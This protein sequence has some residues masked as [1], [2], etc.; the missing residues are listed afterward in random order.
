MVQKLG[1]W[2][3]KFRA[4]G[5]NTTINFFFFCSH[6]ASFFIFLWGLLDYTC[7]MWKRITTGRYLCVGC[8]PQWAEKSFPSVV[9]HWDRLHVLCKDNK[10]L[11]AAVLMTRHVTEC[12]FAKLC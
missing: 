2:N 5:F 9:L 12:N 10:N 11:A 8:F 6:S 4:S 3:K 7:W 1:R